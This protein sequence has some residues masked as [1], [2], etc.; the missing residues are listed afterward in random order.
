MANIKERRVIAIIDAPEISLT[1]NENAGDV[2]IK[3]YC[4]LGWNCED[5]LDPC[6]V[7]TTE[8]VYNRLYDLVLEKWPDSVGAGMFMVNNA[9]GVD[10]HI[11]PNKV[12]LLEGWTIPPVKELAKC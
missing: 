8:A 7:R 10:A 11:P 9:P 2:L 5:T 1:E 3:F 12:H 6:K 4:A